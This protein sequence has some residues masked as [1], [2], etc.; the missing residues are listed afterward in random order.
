MRALIL[1]S[2]LLFAGCIGP[3]EKE[4]EVV[5]ND[6][7][8]VYSYGAMHAEWGTYKLDVDAQGNANFMENTYD[9]NKTNAFKLTDE[10][11]LGLY[12]VILKNNFFELNEEYIDPSIMDGGYSRLT[13]T[14]KG[15]EHS[16]FVK[17][18]YQENIESI[19]AKI[20]QLLLTHS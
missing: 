14:A 16:V 8:L 5:P 9:Q 10:E 4:P 11:L 18:M 2:L 12:T 1:L 6:F 7:Y 17:N 3:S 13:V 15:R 20:H 19:E